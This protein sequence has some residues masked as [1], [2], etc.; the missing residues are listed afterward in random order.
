MRCTKAD[1]NLGP[2]PWAIPQE[3]RALYY[4]TQFSDRCEYTLGYLFLS[5][6]ETN[7]INKS[8]KI[9]KN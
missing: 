7:N 2:I 6:Y 5:T 9:N 1:A 3:S 8:N 4:I